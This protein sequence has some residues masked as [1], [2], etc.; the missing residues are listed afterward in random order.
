MPRILVIDDDRQLRRAIRHVLEAAGYEVL[1][2]ADGAEGLRLHHEQRPDLVLVDIF[3]PEQDGLEFIRS[4]CT[5][6][7]QTKVIA[8]SGGGRTG[9]VDVLHAATAFGAARTLVKPFQ[10]RQLLNAV[11]ELVG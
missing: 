5:E 8:M 6:A 1:E 3:M 11:W 2:A 10:L 9:M 4:V 7:P